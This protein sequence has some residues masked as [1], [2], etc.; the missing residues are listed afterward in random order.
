MSNL[1]KMLK[2]SKFQKGF[3]PTT[4]RSAGNHATHSATEASLTMSN[5][6]FDYFDPRFQFSLTLLGGCRQANFGVVGRLPAR[7]T[8]PNTY[9]LIVCKQYA[10]AGKNSNSMASLKFDLEY[11]V[12]S[13]GRCLSPG[14]CSRQYFKASLLIVDA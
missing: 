11:K 13:I 9:A 2:K 8:L 6:V 3:G 4:Y 5:D 12:A 7:Y 10:G 1:G 14:I